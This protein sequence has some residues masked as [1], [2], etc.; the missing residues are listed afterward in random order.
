MLLPHV[1]RGLVKGICEEGSS[2]QHSLAHAI[3]PRLWTKG[4]KDSRFRMASFV[5]RLIDAE[6]NCVRKRI[7]L[8]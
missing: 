4:T 5:A 3:L 2:V 1:C 7:A 6:G 8:E